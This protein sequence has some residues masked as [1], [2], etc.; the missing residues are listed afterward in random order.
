MKHIRKY[1]ESKDD[2]HLLDDIFID[3]IEDWEAKR[4]KAP[5]QYDFNTY[6][7]I[8]IPVPS[9]VNNPRELGVDKSLVE[10]LDSYID[11][12]SKLVDLCN[13]IKVCLKRVESFF[14]G[15]KIEYSVV[16]IDASSSPIV[17]DVRK[18]I[19]IEVYNFTKNKND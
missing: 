16:V 11:K 10:Y 3:L 2:I 9:M 4:V 17:S 12:S 6:Y 5:P 7:E 19:K 1:N 8:S 15:S 18:F 14:P 13:D